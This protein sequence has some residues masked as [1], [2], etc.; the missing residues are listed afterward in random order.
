MEL[1]VV[2]AIV[3]ILTA[4]LLPALN[5]ARAR[6]KRATCANNLKQIILGVIMYA[7]DNA[8]TL[9][10]FR[11]PNPYPNGEGYFYKEL[12]KTYVGLSGPPA[13]EPLFICPAEVNSPT[14]GRISPHL[15]SD[16]SDY[17]FNVWLRKAKLSALPHPTRT[18]LVMEE[19][20]WIG[21]S[22]H[23]PQSAYMLINNP[24]YWPPWL[25]AVYNNALDEISFADGHVN[26]IRI[27]NDGDRF[28]ILYNPPAGYD[29]QWTKD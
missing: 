28:S 10:A 16:Y 15:Y 21:Y 1:L 24:P 2:I 4:L 19:P 18:V 8:D 14:D 17:F 7:H 29:Y 22:F 5:R 20:A 25:H 12:I 9:F 6:A 13:P 11:K 27:Y 23:Q 3:A 26:Y